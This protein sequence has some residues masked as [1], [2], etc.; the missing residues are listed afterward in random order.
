MLRQ[1]AGVRIGFSYTTARSDAALGT[2]YRKCDRGG[3]YKRPIK[4][5]LTKQNLKSS[6]RLSACLWRAIGK[7]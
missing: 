5:P 6:T 1:N 2:I 4:V 3:E 7:E